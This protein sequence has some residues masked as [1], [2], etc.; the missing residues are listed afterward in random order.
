M[1]ATAIDEEN[2]KE[3]QEKAIGS[4]L[5]PVKLPLV[6]LGVGGGE[7]GGDDIN[8]CSLRRIG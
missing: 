7:E 8:Q 4:F 2:S 6:V 1:Q 3:Q 5:R